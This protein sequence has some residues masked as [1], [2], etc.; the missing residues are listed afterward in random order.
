MHKKAKHPMLK[1]VYSIT[2]LPLLNNIAQKEIQSAR[3]E[4]DF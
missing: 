1:T 3:I 4:L 2:H